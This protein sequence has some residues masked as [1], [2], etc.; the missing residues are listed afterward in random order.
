MKNQIILIFAILLSFAAPAKAQR[1]VRT[2]NTASE[3]WAAN[4]ND[5]STNIFIGGRSSA[6]IAALRLITSADAVLIKQVTVQGNITA[7]DGLGGIYTWFAGDTS[8][9]DD[10]GV[11][12]PNDYTTGGLWKK[13]V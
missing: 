4:L 8:A 9:H 3:A 11:V 5:V 12:R 13:L 2:F 6:N 10:N 7:E 1:Y